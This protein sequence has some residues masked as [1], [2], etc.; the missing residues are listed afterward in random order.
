MKTDRERCSWKTFFY[1]NRYNLRWLCGA[2]ALPPNKHTSRTSCACVVVV[3]QSHVRTHYT[4][5]HNPQVLQ[6]YTQPKRNECVCVCVKSVS[7]SQDCLLCAN[8]VSAH[9]LPLDLL[10]NFWTIKILLLLYIIAEK[11]EREENDVV[12]WSV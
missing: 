2:R 5:R 12:E 1:L 11:R 8:K 3:L 9:K 7:V 10:F 4:E 6:L